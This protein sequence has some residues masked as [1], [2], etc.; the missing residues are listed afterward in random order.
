ML[1]DNLD[2]VSIYIEFSL[3][4]TVIYTH[5]SMYSRILGRDKAF[6]EK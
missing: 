5:I 4:G 6:E 3:L 2:N 1:Q